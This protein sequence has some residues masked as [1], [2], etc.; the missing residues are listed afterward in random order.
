MRGL[1]YKDLYL[2]KGK[3][4]A[5]GASVLFLILLMY[6]VYACVGGKVFFPENIAAIVTDI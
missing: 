3:V 6:I 1:I 2:I 4:L 5:G